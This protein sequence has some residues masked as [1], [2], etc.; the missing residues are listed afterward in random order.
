MPGSDASRDARI[1]EFVARTHLLTGKEIRERLPWNTVASADAIRH[2]AYGTCDDNPLWLDR[3]YARGTQYGQLVAPPAFLCSVHYPFLHGEPMETPLSFLIGEVEFEWCC[4]VLEGDQLSASTRQVGVTEAVDRKGRRLVSIVAETVYRNGGNKEVAKALGTVVGVARRD[5]ESLLDRGIHRY[6]E[7][8]LAAISEAF[9]A[10]TRTGGVGLA[11]EDLVVGD[12]LPTMVRGPLTIGDLICWQAAIG[13]SYRAGTLGFQDIL[14]A[15]H[16]ASVNPVTGWPVRSS[17]QH[18]DFLLAA[19]RGM[20][21]PFDNSL[22]RFAWI[23]PMLTNWMGDTGFLRRLSIQT[24]E[25]L[26]YGD[27]LWYRGTVTE[28]KPEPKAEGVSATVKIVGVNQLG[29]TTTTGMAEVIL[30]AK[31]R[32]RRP[33]M[34]DGPASADSS[35]TGSLVVTEVLDLFAARVRERPE[36]MAVIGGAETVTYSELDERSNRLA[37]RL[38]GYGARPGVLVGLLSGRGV[39]TVVCFLAI[40]KAGAAYLPLDPEQ[41]ETRLEWIVRSAAPG[42]LLAEERLLPKLAGTYPADTADVVLLARSAEARHPRILGLEK[43]LADT[44]AESASRPSLASAP[45]RLAYAMPTSG[46]LRAPSVVALSQAALACSI[47]AMRETLGVGTDDKLLSAASFSFSASVRQLFVPLCQGA[48]VVIA[49]PE[50]QRDPLALLSL[51][52]EQGVT[53]WDTVPTV[54]SYAIETLLSL[55]AD[56]RTN[57][58]D[59]RLRLILTTGETLP[60]R[61]P[62]TWRN[63][64]RQRARMMNLYSQTE[65]V[66]TVCSYLIPEDV[67]LQEGSVPLGRPVA[68]TEVMVLDNLR[69]PVLPGE[70]G[71]IHVSGPRL[72]EGYLRREDLTAD[73]FV[74][75]PFAR[76][77]GERLYRTGDLGRCLPDG[78]LSFTGRADH[79]VK[80]RGQRIELSEVEEALRSH[81]GIVEALAITR[82][83]PSGELR[84]VAYVVTRPEDGSSLSDLKSHLRRILTG[85]GVPEVFV[86]VPA[87][88]R[89]ASGKPDRAAL[90]EPEA[91]RVEG[92]GGNATVPTAVEE[93]LA[94]IWADVLGVQSLSADENFFDLGGHSLNATLIVNRVRQEFGVNLSLHV[95]FD[96][97]TLS[98]CAA[99]IECLLRGNDSPSVMEPG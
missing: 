69:Q 74:P 26:I 98:A 18:E 68:F 20:P 96:A 86:R 95:F 60:W 6:S 72:A 4:V 50:Q 64:V 81:P 22:M 15:P 19:Q 87:L 82:S 70:L 53:I 7:R 45:G 88:P 39:E 41:P 47:Q 33:A 61:V 80:I 38:I 28:L 30:Q 44:V 23:A 5:E 52:K 71:E 14:K 75:S 85:A 58:L 66:G 97:P 91:W 83:D 9:K 93:A 48:T 51:I 55:P 8:D 77:R 36:A 3:D 24:G 10:E 16:T 17:Q 57:L 89:T 37:H 40:L 43:L 78:N 35:L 21:G 46:T 63:V 29:L 92:A 1:D 84:L 90:P 42:L 2:F 31:R 73:R 11:G 27:T 49:G 62:F 79:R 76:Q 34:D 25:P 65:T 99:A 54:W 94:A 56:V 59:N 32:R 67:A 13:P 12:K